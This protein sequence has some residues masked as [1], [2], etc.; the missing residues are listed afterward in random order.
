MLGLV[1]ASRRYDPDRGV[2]FRAFAAGRIRG[3]VLDHVRAADWAPR[4]LRRVARALDE[5]EHVL[6]AHHHRTPDAPEV[7]AAIGLSGEQLAHLRGRL[8]ASVVVSLD[9]PVA[10]GDATVVAVLADDAAVDPVAAVVSLEDRGYLRDAVLAL[11]ARHRTVIV[12]YF[13]E[14]RTSEQIADHLG[15]TESRVSQLRS[16]ALEMLREGIE[17]QY[18]PGGVATVAGRRQAGLGRVARRKQGY[19]AAIRAA[20]EPRRRLTVSADWHQQAD[21]GDAR[22]AALS[23]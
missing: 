3:A 18:Q 12:A 22:L 23:A 10:D 11:P 2:P 17:A 13:L 20:S 15:V 21:D 4:S 19:A 6:A 8:D 16:H 5:A 14:G 1:E 7:A 9:A